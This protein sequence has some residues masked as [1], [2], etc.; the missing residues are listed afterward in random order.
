MPNI[1]DI[2]AEKKFPT[3]I[4]GHAI[5]KTFKEVRKVFPEIG[6]PNCEKEVDVDN[7][8]EV[9]AA[10]TYLLNEIK[11]TIDRRLAGI[12]KYAIKKSD[13][14]PKRKNKLDNTK[15]LLSAVNTKLT[16][17]NKKFITE[18][19]G[20]I[21]LNLP[22]DIVDVDDKVAFKKGEGLF[23][24]YNK[25]NETLRG[26][27]FLAMTKLEDLYQFKE[28]SSKN[29]PALKYKI[30]FSSDGAEG[31]WD[32]ATMSMRGINSCQTWGGGNATHIVGSIVDPF[33]G[34]IYLTSGVKF[35]EHGSKMMRRC[36]VR[37]VVDEKKKKPFLALERMYPSMEK[38]SLDAF[39]AFLKEK[40]DNK[41]EIK[42]LDRGVGNGSSSY[43]PM[44]K[45][46]S[47]LTTYD[48]P[49][50]DSGMEYRADINDC[51][52]RVKEA[53]A[54]KLDIIY[55]AFASKVVAAAK[56]VKITSVPEECKK[57]LKILTGRDYNYDQ[58]YTLYERLDHYIQKL[59]SGLGMGKYNDGGMF[60]RDGI[61]KLLGDKLEDRIFDIV[62]SSANSIPKSERR[63]G[64]S[65]GN[66]GYYSELTDDVVR[67]IAKGA[68]VK[69]ETYF[70]NELKKIKVVE[71]KLG[72]KNDE[73]NAIIPI[74]TKL[75]S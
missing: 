61:E 7:K 36:V 12:N 35:N 52:A 1:K 72:E 65:N 46:V 27:H 8:G 44:S 62:K 71:M 6:L 34:I 63:A 37:F 70:N 43:V 9:I 75:L 14:K 54:Y 41:F 53:V 20:R 26:G 4:T 74:Y 73:L 51:K 24:V 18:N 10:A 48:Q 2:F 67:A 31:A 38:S 49:Y 13:M 30:R 50:R 11:T 19:N 15:V 66:K 28:F 69:L 17:S 3:F 45:I 55:G 5:F 23:R 29:V 16:K 39:V 47:S 21:T 25:L 32:I 57:T 56:N 58:S 64:F 60:L 22:D 33:T 42:Y 68:V 59:F 40:T